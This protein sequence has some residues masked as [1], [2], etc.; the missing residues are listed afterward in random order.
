VTYT[1]V[2]RLLKPDLLTRRGSIH[3]LPRQ[4]VMGL[5]PGFDAD[6]HGGRDRDRFVERSMGFVPVDEIDRVGPARPG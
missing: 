4:R 5:G 1:A 6:V 3:K 2:C